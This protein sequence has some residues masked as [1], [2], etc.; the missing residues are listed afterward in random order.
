MSPTCRSTARRRARSTAGFTLPE[1]MIGLAIVAL[2]S[3][4]S[5]PMLRSMLEGH[6]V[7]TASFE[8][9]LTLNLAR[10]EAIKRA[11]PVTVTPTGGSWNAGWRIFDATGKLI[12][13]QPALPNG[14][15]ISGPNTLVYEKDGRLPNLGD[16]AAFDVEVQ[17]A[18]TGS[19]VRCVRV[20]LAGK[21][22]TRKGTC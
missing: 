15:A 16:T 21:P 6:R 1:A 11:T 3:V 8:L 2:L 4:M 13:L 12:K 10:S 20:D 5:M 19:P 18:T 17:D 7:K 14:I 9:F 22:A